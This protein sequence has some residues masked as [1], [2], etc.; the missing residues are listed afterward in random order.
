MGT[1][2]RERALRAGAVRESFK[3]EGSEQSIIDCSHVCVILN[4]DLE[5][6]ILTI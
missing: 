3:E 2:R 6:K 5:E 1:R 4:N